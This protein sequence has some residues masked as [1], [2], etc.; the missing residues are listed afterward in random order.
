[1]KLLYPDFCPTAV[2][3]NMNLVLS[4]HDGRDQNVMR[5]IGCAAT[6]LKE[7][8]NVMYGIVENHNCVL[9]LSNAEHQNWGGEGGE[10]VAETVLPDSYCVSR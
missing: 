8:L 7:R 4:Y 10:G 3:N 9:T 1:M 5:T 6:R 2:V